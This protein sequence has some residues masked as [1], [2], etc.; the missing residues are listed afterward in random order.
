MN[1]R[2]VTAHLPDE[3]AEKLDALAE[4]LD[5]P[6]GWVVKEALATYIAVDEER[7]QQT[8]EALR[9]VE[10]GETVEHVEVEAW[11]EQVGRRGAAKR[12]PAR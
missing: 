9:E 8:L 11:A 6:R 5:R 3:L 1:T 10:A 12:R 2:V 4:R 7:H